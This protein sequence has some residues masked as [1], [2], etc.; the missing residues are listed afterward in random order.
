MVPTN[1]PPPS[2][3]PGTGGP[4]S[5]NAPAPSYISAGD[6]TIQAK[7]LNDIIAETRVKILVPTR[8]EHFVPPEQIIN[9]CWP[10]PQ[11]NG[12]WFSTK[13]YSDVE[14]YLFDPF[15][16]DS[17]KLDQV[18]MAWDV[19]FEDVEFSEELAQLWSQGLATIAET[20]CNTMF[21]Y[22]NLAPWW[23]ADHFISV[24]E[25]D[26]N[27]GFNRDCH[28]YS[29]NWIPGSYVPCNVNDIEI[30]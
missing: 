17:L 20:G 22:R 29:T 11:G 18:G 19:Q 6:S 12:T 1:P 5:T 27:P 25:H 15:L 7:Y 2:N 8:Q 10:D 13:L 4:G 3:I 30:P 9:T 16:I 21:C 24:H 23:D 14:I 26:T 28:V